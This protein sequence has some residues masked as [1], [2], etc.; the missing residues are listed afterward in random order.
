MSQKNEFYP[1]PDDLAAYLLDR[2]LWQVP[3][4]MFLQKDESGDSLPVQMFEPSAGKGAFARVMAATGNMVTA[5]D[6]NFDDPQIEGVEWMQTDLESLHTLLE[7]D[8]PFDLACGNP[9]FSLAE[10]HLRLLLKM[11]RRGGYIGFLLRVGF[12]ASA[13]RSEF[14]KIYPPKH[15]YILPKRPSFVWSWTCKKGEVVENWEQGRAVTEV[16]C[17]HKWVDAIELDHAHCPKC[18][19][20]GLQVCK[21]DQYDY[22]FAIWEV[23]QSPGH[24]TT[25]SWLHAQEGEDE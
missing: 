2:F 11:V 6:P 4:D 17:G 16:G 1:T 24:T 19:H 10:A 18:G 7:G 5:I 9:P 20:E 3:N 15:V 22:M 14:F 13:K 8:R 12:L 25:L 21:T 23:G